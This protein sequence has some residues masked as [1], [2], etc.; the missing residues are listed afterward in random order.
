MSDHVLSMDVLSICEVHGC[1]DKYMGNYVYSPSMDVL[2]TC[3][4]EIVLHL[5]VHI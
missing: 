2:S 1:L 4:C 3:I 5:H